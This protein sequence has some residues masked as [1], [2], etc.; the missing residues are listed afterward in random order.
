[1]STSCDRVLNMFKALPEV[2]IQVGGER[3]KHLGA[4][5]RKRRLAWYLED[6]HGDGAVVVTCKAPAGVNTAMVD[7]DSERYFIPSYTGSRGLSG[8]HSTSTISTGTESNFVSATPT[9]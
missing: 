5:V 3:D 1:M 2:D 7:S 8:Y 9:E 6:H 4:S